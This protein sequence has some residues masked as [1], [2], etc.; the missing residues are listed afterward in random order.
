M[1]GDRTGPETV[2]EAA[3]G[4]EQ[5]PVGHQPGDPT[6]VPGGQTGLLVGLTRR[7]LGCVGELL[8]E[9]VGGA[10]LVVLT[11]GSLVVSFVLAQALYAASPAAAYALAA[12]GLLGLL[13]GI[14]HRRRPKEERSRLGRI[15]AGVTGLLGFWLILC[16]GYASVDVALG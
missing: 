13:H 8:L 12:V 2:R 10:V 4:P 14:R 15:T 3:P 1:A 11:T 7:T 5:E 16:V 6:P 9:L